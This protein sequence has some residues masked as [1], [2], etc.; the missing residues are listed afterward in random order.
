VFK[1][2]GKQAEIL[3]KKC[4]DRHEGA[5]P[6]K[7]PHARKVAGPAPATRAMFPTTGKVETPPRPPDHEVK[8]H[9]LDLTLLQQFS[10]ITLKQFVASQTPDSLGHRG[11]PPRQLSKS[12]NISTL[13]VGLEFR[14]GGK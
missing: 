11:V 8:F 12:L 1:P 9:M 6:L 7:F 2:S 4:A 10:Q 14:G 3:P 5:Q 13:Q